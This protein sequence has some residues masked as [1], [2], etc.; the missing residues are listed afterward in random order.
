MRRHRP[1]PTALLLTLVAASLLFGACTTEPPPPAE[2]TEV[3]S[4]AWQGTIEERNG[5]VIVDNPAA[6]LWDDTAGPR[7]AFEPDGAFGGP[8][9]GITGIAGAVVDR[10]GNLHV[11]DP[12]AG[13][14]IT[15]DAGGDVVHRAGSSGTGA[16]QL[17]DVRGMAY[18]GADAVWLVN[19]NGARLDAWGLDGAHRRSI[20][21]ADLELTDVY[22]GGFLSPD[23]LVL[24][25][26]A[27]DHMAVNHYVVVDLGEPASVVRRFS[28]NAQPM[29][30]IPPGVVLQLSHHFSGGRILVGT[31]EQYV[32]R[33]YDA[34][35]TLLRRVNRPVDYLRR[36]GFAR[37]GGQFRGVALGGLAA[38]I[39]L[40]SGHWLVM[41]SWP[42]NVDNP[43]P[44]AET[45]VGQRPPIDWESSLDL[46]DQE[47][48]FLYSLT[49]PGSPAPDIGRPWTVGPQGR[50]YTV[51]AD[52]FPQVRRYRVVLRPPSE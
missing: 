36:P 1:V 49:Y 32:L 9:S 29:V 42:T 18:D 40:D 26:H 11:Y 2:E 41:A 3:A 6:P 34:E 13:S 19:Q 44:F 35:G 30:P 39:V 17:A 24:V 43:N 31:W 22:M 50:L 16:E 47:G 46:F 14:L 10:D 20:A 48:R 15:L 5:V 27:D 21:A 51:V 37:V 38:P 33:T 52:P 25:A 4:S 8:A 7:L 45:P 23:R 12:L 28:V